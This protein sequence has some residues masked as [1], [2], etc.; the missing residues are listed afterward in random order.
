[1]KFVRTF[2]KR[3][4][5]NPSAVGLRI[6]DS[7]A[8]TAPW[9]L[10]VC[11]VKHMVGVSWFFLALLILMLIF[12]SPRLS[13]RY[14]TCGLGLAIVYGS[15]TIPLTFFCF[16]LISAVFDLDNFGF[17]MSKKAS[18][19]NGNNW[20]DDEIAVDEDFLSRDS[21]NSAVINPGSSLNDENGFLVP[22]V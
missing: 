3:H 14:V 22:Y 20:V 15:I 7:F 12:N 8:L 4:L 13:F 21:F 18:V 11:F 10:S 19:E 9:I 5:G 16:V 2:V 6:A 1:M 17:N